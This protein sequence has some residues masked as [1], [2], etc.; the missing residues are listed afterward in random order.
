MSQSFS[1]TISHRFKNWRRYALVLGL[2]LWAFLGFILAQALV[3]ALIAVLQALK[4][5]VENVNQ[6]MLSTILAAAIYT[7]SVGLVL[8]VPW[9]VKRRPTTIKDLGL[10]A[11]PSGLDFLWAPAGYVVYAIA[12]VLV[13]ALATIVLPFVDF[14]QV[15]QTGFN[16][17]TQQYELILAFVSLVVV[18]PVAE[19]VLFRGY[20]L[21]KLRK[22]APLWIAIL[23][24]SLTFAI[25][26]F[27]WNVGID[28]FVL[29]IVLC[30][31]RV[32]TGTLW[33]PIMLHML[34]NGIAFYFLF[35]NPT[36]IGTLG[37]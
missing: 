6:A 27:A 21:G 23:V 18:A 20:L 4:V 25:V 14:Q 15:Q 37:G 7:V 26:H 8:M 16:G 35:I 10:T 33:A 30:V 34:K 1:E 12:S 36:L 22:R 29:S 28:V 11:S 3:F 31:L 9:W 32:M 19:E 5:P 17:I 2:P 24:T 13:M